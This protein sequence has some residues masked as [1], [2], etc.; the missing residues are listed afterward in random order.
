MPEV[1]TVAQI[2]AS[3]ADALDA[4]RYAREGDPAGVWIESERPVRRLGLR[5]EAGRAPYDWA[6]GLDAVLLHRPFGLWPARFP[7]GVGV[8]AYHRAL[9]ERL[10][11]G[12]NP[13]LANA[14]GAEPEAEPLRR[15]GK[16]V[17]LVG[18][19]APTP[20]AALL[21]R[22]ADVLGGVE[23]EAGPAPAAPVERF[24]LVGAMTEALVEDAA[25]RGAA[26][27]VTGQVRQPAVAAAGERGVRVVAVGQERGERW[28]LRRLGGLITERWPAVEVVDRG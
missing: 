25:G 3:L 19:L 10:S 23:A 26:V 1:P 27:Y 17:G 6:E 28:G 8:L 13:A 7:D 18:A 21:D 11:V 24:A 16:T 14:L 22:L 9:D 5:L 2:A 4:D 12:H 15:G 20:Y